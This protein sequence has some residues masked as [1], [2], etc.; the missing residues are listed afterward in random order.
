MTRYQKLQHQSQANQ[1]PVP[2]N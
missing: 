2:K 1:K